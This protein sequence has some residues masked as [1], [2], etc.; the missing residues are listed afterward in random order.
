[1]YIYIYVYIYIYTASDHSLRVLHVE[2]AAERRRKY[3]I[4]F[5]FGLFREYINL[6]CVRIPVIY[7]VN[8]A[9][10]VIHILVVALQEYVN[11]YS[12]R[13]LRVYR[14]SIRSVYVG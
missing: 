3:G 11:T 9:A 8:Q 4:M 1:M 14:Q 7:R 6:E 2:Y 13:R 10:Y 5:I 12:T